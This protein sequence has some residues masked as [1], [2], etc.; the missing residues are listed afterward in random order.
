MDRL[1]RD[2][3]INIGAHGYAH[4]DLEVYRREGTLKPREFLS[5]GA[6][7]TRLIL[8]GLAGW[9][10]A[11]F[12]KTHAGFV[13]PAWGYRA[14]ITKLAARGIFRYIAD[15][16]QHL[17]EGEGGGLFGTVHDGCVD[18]FE[19]WRSGM[20]GISM[21][22]RSL[23]AAYL[24]AGLPVHVMLHGPL[25]RDPLTR[26][27]KWI[28]VAV[29]GLFLAILGMVIVAAR[30]PR[31]V[32]I[33]LLGELG[34]VG[35]AYSLRRGCGWYLRMA[36]ARLSGR[37]TIHD[38]AREAGGAGA[39]WL[40]LEELADHMAAYPS[41]SML[42]VECADGCLRVQLNCKQPVRKPLSIHFSFPVLRAISCPEVTIVKAS[43][44]VLRVGP[45]A[46]GAY[47]FHIYTVSSN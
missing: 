18:L 1:F 13:A 27:R 38:L 19:T 15:S 25:M 44:N 33:V 45:L 17:Q 3:E 23:F 20:C 39:A 8:E 37:G 34:V 2:G 16:S 31:W 11:D 12:G 26:R 10:R 9:L 30:G 29:G 41:V 42:S 22:D 7:R 28:A 46:A 47:E 14:G 6:A 40:F 24:D 35:I 36:P 32:A 43:P 4:L 21:A 5:M